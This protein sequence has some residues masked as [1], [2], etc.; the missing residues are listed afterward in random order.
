MRRPTALAILPVLAIIILAA[1]AGLSPGGRTWQAAVCLALGAALGFAGWRLAGL[2]LAGEALP[3][4]LTGAFALAVALSVV[5]ATGLGLCGLLT[6]R[7]FE[8]LIAVAAT[9]A[10]P[11][12]RQ[13]RGSASPPGP[14]SH[15]PPTSRERGRKAAL[16]DGGEEPGGGAPL[17]G[18]GRAMGEGTG[19]RPL[20]GKAT[21]FKS[22]LPLLLLLVPVSLLLVLTLLAI[23]Q[24]RSL[25]PGVL[26]YDDTSY[27][28]SAVAVWLHSHDLR[29]I[30]FAFGDGT[31]TFY[32]FGSELWSWALLVPFRDSD[33]L[34]RWSQLP[35]ALF[36]LVAIAAVARRLGLSWPTALLAVVSYWSVP[37]AFPELALSAGND[38]A[39]AF[40]MVAGVDA[41][42]L[43]AQRPDRSRSI[44]AGIVLG[45]LVGTKYIGVLFVP[46]L[47]AVWFAA[48][49]GPP[50]EEK[51]SR[52]AWAWG[53][54]AALLA[55]GYTYLRNA[56]V[57]GNPLFPA[58]VTLWGWQILPGWARAAPATRR[59]EEGSVDL[60]GLFWNH[61]DL[62]GPLFRWVILLGALLGGLAALWTW[63]RSPLGRATAA[64]ALLPFAIVAVFAYLHDHR[65][66]RYVFAA[67]ALAGVSLGLAVEKTPP[68]VRLWLAGL[69]SFALALAALAV[70]TTPGQAAAVSAVAAI[71]CGLC[72]LWAA[73]PLSRSGWWAGGTRGGG[74]GGGGGW[75]LLPA[76]AALLVLAVP[77]VLGLRAWTE[78]YQ[79]HR[80]DLWPDA[81][82]LERVTGGA[83]AVI[84]YLGGNRPYRYAGRRLQNRVEIVPA[85][86]PVE[87]GYFDW[88]GNAD[89]PYHDGR[90]QAWSRNLSRLGVE[91]VLVDRND[92]PSLESEVRELRWMRA[93]PEQ[94]QPL[95]RDGSCEVWRFDS[96]S[97]P[98]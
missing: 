51:P 20:W 42:L 10:L 19:V 23:V 63:R 57:T 56:A 28:L 1:D 61:A 70:R 53:A 72:A 67:L 6:P 98:R 13:S 52:L 40:F 89:F 9:A 5:S 22:R 87:D 54:G 8:L 94:F 24:R 18:A 60:F 12:F 17:P 4:R 77:A 66:I 90:Y 88:Q 86:G 62:L 59:L 80:L 96:R 84:A 26:S 44:Y 37:R 47:A 65:E 74:D 2:L 7:P 97:G 68:R 43:A 15:R 32:P 50:P 45:L 39:L 3:A 92:D 41:V 64:V 27:H 55:G 16:L 73:A 30:K 38:H 21:G 34:A 82:A 93:H 11:G 71:V 25:P 75:R 78:S 29:M 31:T 79:K 85:R 33:V 81:A 91:L 95:W 76:L 35:F 69:L 58:P 14:L 49:W 83:P 46:L 36:T 48:R